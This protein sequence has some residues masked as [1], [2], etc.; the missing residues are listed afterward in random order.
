MHG[1][2][3]KIE[4]SDNKDTSSYLDTEHFELTGKWLIY[5]GDVSRPLKDLLFD[6]YHNIG[7]IL[8]KTGTYPMTKP[9]AWLD[10]ISYIATDPIGTV[11]EMACDEYAIS[12]L[13]YDIHV[14]K[15][16][17]IYKR[18]DINFVEDGDVV[19]YLKDL[20]ND[21]MIRR[22]YADHL[23][24]EHAKMVDDLKS[25]P[26]KDRM[27]VSLDAKRKKMTLYEAHKISLELAESIGVVS[28]EKINPIKT[29]ETIVEKMG[30]NV[31]GKTKEEIIDKI[32]RAITAN[33]EGLSKKAVTIRNKHRDVVST[34]LIPNYTKYKKA[35]HIDE[36]NDL[37]YIIEHG[38]KEY[39]MTGHI[40]TSDDIKRMMDDHKEKASNMNHVKTD[41]STMLSYNDK[42]KLAEKKHP[43][44]KNEP[45]DLYKD[46]IHKLIMTNEYA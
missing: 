12:T 29:L 8:I 14:R 3:T 15:V 31:H 2:E 39:V 5:I 37:M 21:I 42:K 25:R 30:L 45:D 35:I 40:P 41:T 9:K 22:H 26:L 6:F 32:I 11:E 17:P 1:I 33:K 19:G 38:M 27:N 43:Q 36:R 7:H 20:N 24:T 44:R 13:G 10:S 18:T 28:R 46:R 4:W 23:L 34:F 16:I